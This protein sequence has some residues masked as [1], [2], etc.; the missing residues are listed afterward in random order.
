[1]KPRPPA[2]TMAVLVLLALPAAAS[3]AAPTVTVSGTTATFADDGSNADQVN[4]AIGSVD[5]P[6]T[7]KY[8]FTDNV[9]M[10]SG[11]PVVGMPAS[12][13]AIACNVLGGTGVDV[14]L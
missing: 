10:S 4:V 9:S 7:T 6:G 14:N 3:A 11:N 8:T 2:G 1:M 5:L 13:T 12:G